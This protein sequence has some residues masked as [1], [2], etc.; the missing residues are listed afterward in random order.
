[1]KKVGIITLY[2][3]N[4]NYGGL[5]QAYA[6]VS[7]LNK[8]GVLC[9][10]ISFNL[11]KDAPVI[12]TSE[13]L[14]QKLKRKGIKGIFGFVKRKINYLKKKPS[15]EKVCILEKQSVVFDRFIDEKVLHS[16][17]V[18][19]YK[20]IYETLDN[21]DAFIT[22]SDQV[23]NFKFYREEFFLDFVPSNKTKISYAAS[24]GS[25]VLS[26]QQKIV[27]RN[28]LKDYKAIS[29]R[30]E[31]NLA[32]IED[33]SQI[34]PIAVLD[35]TLLLTKK[36]W[37]TLASERVIKDKYVY[38][39]FLGNNKQSKKIAQKFA[40]EHNLKTVNI[41]YSSGGHFVKRDNFGDVKLETASPEEFISLIKH[42][43]YVF[44]DS[45]HAV[46]FSNVFKKDY[47]VFDRDKNGDMN[48]RII[49]ITSL[50]NEKERFVKNSIQNK[51]SYIKNLNPIDYTK[52][53]PKFEELYNR[54][55]NFLKENL[56]I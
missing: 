1:M 8:Q 45:F 35:P 34:R 21:Y 36:D 32:L 38:C 19:N 37:E 56:G 18:Y 31:S 12:T 47:F 54:S 33:I 52:P 15:K 46:V 10:Q 50:F 39:Y 55:V 14:L 23:W 2:Y 27:M 24:L 25:N 22:G 44:T 51:Y 20:N 13:T 3:K 7:F 30:E 53:N 29:L 28:S 5:L 17:K 16:N 9:E 40:K 4:Y 41:L 48:S 11:K 49:D 42:A 26:E 6:L 43:E